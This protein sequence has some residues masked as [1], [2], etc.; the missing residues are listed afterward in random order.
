MDDKTKNQGMTEIQLDAV[1]F[2]QGILAGLAERTAFPVYVIWYDKT[3]GGWCK[4]IAKEL[5]GVEA[6]KK[7]IGSMM[8]N[9]IESLK[10]LDNVFKKSG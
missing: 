9:D 4:A 6:V 8:W 10:L 5:Q 7:Q 2:K 1:R 3:K